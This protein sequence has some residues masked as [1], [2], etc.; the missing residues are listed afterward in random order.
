MS[1]INH[2]FTS[3]R[4]DARTALIP[5]ITAGDPEPGVTVPLMHALVRGGAD[6]IEL[7]VPFSDPMADGPVIQR[8]SERALVHGTSLRDVIGMVVEFRKKNSDTPVIL[9]GYL[10]P[11]EVMGYESFASVAANAGVDGV[12]IVDMPP[13]ESE[14]LRQGLNQNG[15]DQVFLIA[16][17]TSEERLDRICNSASGFLYYVSLKGVTGSN[18]LDVDSVAEK[19]HQI[20]AKTDL[21]VGVGFGIKDAATAAQV[22]KI[23]DAVIVGS[24]LVERVG[25]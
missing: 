1:K 13:E 14:S 23:S 10:N 2:C 7:G 6:I 19:L 24:A 20:R 21:P 12:L 22:G 17:T 25:G 5:F 9:M 15:L 3:L 18:R 4:K 11:V 8:A 16:P